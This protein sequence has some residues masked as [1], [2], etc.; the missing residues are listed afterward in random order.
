MKRIITS[1]SAMA[2]PEGTRVAYT[3][4]EV[5]VDGQILSRHNTGAFL[6]VQT[7]ELAAVQTLMDAAAQRL[8][9]EAEVTP[10]A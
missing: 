6:A 7:G 4:S 1:I 9:P 3:Y 8:E 5:D 10:D 2:A